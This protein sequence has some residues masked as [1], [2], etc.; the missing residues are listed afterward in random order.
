MSGAFPTSPHA[1]PRPGWIQ[2]RL[3]PRSPGSAPLSESVWP[4][5]L[6]PRAQA[7][8]GR[9]Q[10]QPQ[11]LHGRGRRPAI[12][13]GSHGHANPLTLRL[14]Q[15]LPKTAAQ[16][17]LGEP[18]QKSQGKQGYQLLSWPYLGTRTGQPLGSTCANVTSRHQ[19]APADPP[20]PTFPRALHSNGLCSGNKYTS[21]PL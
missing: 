1:R 17:Q 14:W 16:Q 9:R 21:G 15:A 19:P 10:H 7:M 13:R 2:S 12:L 4:K 6:F 5:E 20:I 18:W 8:P 3:L 11:R